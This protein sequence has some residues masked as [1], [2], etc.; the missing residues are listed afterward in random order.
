MD[1]MQPNKNDPEGYRKAMEYAK[2]FVVK[3]N[4]DYSDID[5]P[6]MFTQ[7]GTLGK[8][9]LQFKKFGVKEAEFLFT[10]I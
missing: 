9:L 8:T 7:F 10:D 4:F 2:D 6:R 3:T 5:S 1:P